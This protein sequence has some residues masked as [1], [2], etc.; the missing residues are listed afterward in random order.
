ML[1]FRYS[2][3]R[4]VTAL[5]LIVFTEISNA[6][7]ATAGSLVI[8]Q[9][10]NGRSLAGEVNSR[11]DGVDLWIHSTAPSVVIL[12][13]IPWS[14][15]SAA[16]VGSEPIP[17]TQLREALSLLKAP[18][19]KSVFRQSATSVP[20][21]AT[22]ALRVASL[23]ILARLG[24]WDRDIEPDGLD[25]RIN[26]L[27]ADGETVAVDGMITLR[28]IGRRLGSQ[29]RLETPPGFGFWTDGGS[30]REYAPRLNTT[31]YVELGRWSERLSTRDAAAGYRLKLP[32]RSVHPE[33][34][35]D[36][37]LDGELTAHLN[38]RGQNIQ[39]VST[40]VQLRSFS[41]LREELQ[42]HRRTRYFLDEYTAR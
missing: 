26:P 30:P 33:F 5:A 10:R 11:T 18:V 17:E 37:A 19:P 1:S 21:A 39:Q 9:L 22:P 29:D 35:L 42:L 3:S 25:V 13:A 8:I 6:P 28:L 23:E 15:V 12:S 7:M 31:R 41:P 32:F 40:P 24:N 20:R 4:L 16:R 36:V 38:V 34:D 27:T 2:T 14:E